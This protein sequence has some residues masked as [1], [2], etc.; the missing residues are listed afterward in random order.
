MDSC[1]Q[2]FFSIAGKIELFNK[3]SSAFKRLEKLSRLIGG[4]IKDTIFLITAYSSAH[5]VQ[6]WKEQAAAEN[7]STSVWRLNISRQKKTE[8]NKEP[9]LLKTLISTETGSE[10]T[11]AMQLF[12]PFYVELDGLEDI[13]LSFNRVMLTAKLTFTH[14][15]T[16]KNNKTE[17]N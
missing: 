11:F 2:N 15:S 17:L 1:I 7:T 10:T 14:R 9:K 3:D 6:P 13:L 12:C 16:L 4:N 8:T 5:F